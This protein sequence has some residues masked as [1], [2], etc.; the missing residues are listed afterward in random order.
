MTIETNLTMPEAPAAGVLVRPARRQ[1]HP[2]IRRVVR[3][4]YLEYAGAMPPRMFRRRVEA[5]TPP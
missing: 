4:A 5:P 2:A 1:D 3:D